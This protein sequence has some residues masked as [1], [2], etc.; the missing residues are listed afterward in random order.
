MLCIIIEHE[1]RGLEG[2][3]FG[4]CCFGT[5][6]LAL[7]ALIAIS[8]SICITIAIA[9]A[10]PIAIHITIAITIAHTTTYKAQ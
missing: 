6:L 9:T 3:G 8:I 1:G 10:I 2:V 7:W 4:S 5:L